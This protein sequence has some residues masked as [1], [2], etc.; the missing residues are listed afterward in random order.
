[1]APADAPPRDRA[2]EA[3]VARAHERFAAERRRARRSR[4]QSGGG[5]L[6]NLI[7]IGGLK[8]GTTSLHH[9]LNL[10]PE[11]EMS[12]PKEL[13]FFVSEL[14]WPLRR[15]W[16]A[17]HFSPEAPVRGESSPHYTNLPRFE[18]VAERMRSVLDEPRLVYMVRDPIDRLLSHYLHN[19]GGG[20]EDRP[21]AEALAEPQNAYVSRS[22]YFLQLE[23]FLRAFGPPAIE[24]VAREELKDDRAATMRRLFAFLGVEPDFH[25]EQFER[26]WETGTAKTGGRFRL[27]DRAVRLPG[28]RAL[29]RNFDR[30]PESLRWLVERVVHDPR[31]GEVSKPDL[32]APLRE[33]LVELFRADVA[34]LE[35]L[36]GRRFGWLS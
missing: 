25:S 3:M 6:P 31:A 26:E 1:L 17:S 16:Y 32:P 21:L 5:A 36:A 18:G 11:V 8:C 14:N 22:R 33:R 15:D 34:R 9:Y 24:I 20:Y 30:L 28:L 10:H 23:P 35:E 4:R 29:D 27:M 2:D 12:R 19:V 13:N 7:V